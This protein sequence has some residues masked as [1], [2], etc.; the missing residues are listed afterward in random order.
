MAGLSQQQRLAVK[1]QSFK[2]RVSRLAKEGDLA[3][4]IQT[5]E[6]VQRS[7]RAVVDVQHADTVFEHEASVSTPNTRFAIMLKMRQLTKRAVRMERM[8]ERIDDWAFDVFEANEVSNGSP[9]FMITA[10]LL[11]LHGVIDHFELHVPTLHKLLHRV[12]RSTVAQVD[13]RPPASVCDA[14]A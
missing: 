6:G 14:H 5:L 11:E 2:V 4:Q 10:N 12:R 1:T 3:S 9:L 8:L 13:V 7:T